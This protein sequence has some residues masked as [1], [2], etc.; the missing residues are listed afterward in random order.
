MTVREDILRDLDSGPK[1][2]TWIVRRHSVEGGPD[3]RKILRR[4]AVDGEIVQD[5][6]IVEMGL[7]APV[8]R[9]RRRRRKTLINGV[10]DS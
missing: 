3:V 2:E 4:M 9:I 10:K 1:S 7:F 8:Y 6:W 5:D